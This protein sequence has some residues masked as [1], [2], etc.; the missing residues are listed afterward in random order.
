[1][2]PDIRNLR[3]VELVFYSVG[4]Y[5]WYSHCFHLQQTVTEM[6]TI[7]ELVLL[8]SARIKIQ[9]DIANLDPAASK[10]AAQASLAKIH[11]LVWY[12]R[13]LSFCWI[14]VTVFDIY[15]EIHTEHTHTDMFMYVNRASTVLAICQGILLPVA[16]F[17]LNPIIRLK[18]RIL[19]TVQYN[20]HCRR[21][22]TSSG[23]DD[24]NDDSLRRTQGDRSFSVASIESEFDYIAPPLNTPNSLIEFSDSLFGRGSQ[25]SITSNP[26][27]KT[28]S[29]GDS[30]QQ[31]S[32]GRK[33]ST[34]SPKF[35][36]KKNSGGVSPKGSP[37][38][39]ARKAA[40]PS[41]LG[42]AFLAT[43]D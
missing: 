13:I 1:M 43:Y 26:I 34:G 23:G 38:E 11:K 3:Y 17:Q 6:W 42:V 24:N 15:Q 30:P 35:A 40:G 39:I 33:K 16:F 36:F 32:N 5:L 18:W 29:G 14:L 2:F 12:P 41:G 8:F 7:K 25:T 19:L 4:F 28:D 27:F 37:G 9:R 10:V 21:A 31:T 22:N 20:K